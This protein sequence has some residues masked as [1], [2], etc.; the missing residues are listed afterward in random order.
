M[1]KPSDRIYQLIGRTSSDP[2]WQERCLEAVIE[3][4]DEQWEKEQSAKPL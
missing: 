4:L 3:Y 2:E 1:E